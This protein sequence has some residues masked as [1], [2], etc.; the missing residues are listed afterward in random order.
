M[1]WGANSTLTRET[2]QQMETM[3]RKQYERWFRWLSGWDNYPFEKFSLKVTGWAVSDSSLFEGADD[4][5]KVYSGLSDQA[6]DPI[7]NPGCSRTLQLD[8]DY[9]HCSEGYNGRYHQFFLID[10]SWGNYNMDAA[11]GPGVDISL[12]GWQTVGSKLGDWSILI[13]ELV[14]SPRKKKVMAS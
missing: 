5:I 4:G 10:P 8:G 6:G 3:Y 13:H 14:S 2:R 9:S 7:C 1:R 12:F 11:S